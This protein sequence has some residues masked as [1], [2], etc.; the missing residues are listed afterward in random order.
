MC[1]ITKKYFVRYFQLICES[2][3]FKEVLFQEE[4]IVCVVFVENNQVCFLPKTKRK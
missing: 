3:A 1:D 2:G 4:K